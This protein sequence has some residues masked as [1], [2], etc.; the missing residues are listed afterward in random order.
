MVNAAFKPPTGVKCW[1]FRIVAILL[2]LVFV[3]GLELALRIVGFGYPSSFLVETEVQ[4]KRALV[5]NDR[6]GWR[7]FGQ[8]Y[9]RCPETFAITP[10]ASGNTVRIFVLG[11]SAAAGDPQPDFGLPIMLDA[12]LSLRYPATNFEVV[13]VA[14]TAINSHVIREIARDCRHADGDI[15]VLYMGNNEVVGPF[16]GGTVFGQQVPPMAAIRANLALK[17]T[18]TGQLLTTLL[19]RVHS[20][21]NG[22]ESWGGMKMFLDQQVPADDPRMTRVYDHFQRNLED[23]I[24]SGLQSGAGLVVCNVAVNLKDC[25]PFSSDSR[26]LQDEQAVAAWKDDVQRGSDLQKQGQWEAALAAYEEAESQDGHVAMLFFRKGQC[27]LALGRTEQ[28]LFAFRQA[29]DLDT[30]RFRCDSRL[31]E[32]VSSVMERINDPRVRFADTEAALSTASPDHIPGREFFCDHVHLTWEG[33]WLLAKTIADEVRELLPEQVKNSAEALAAW[34]SAE[35]CA[36]RLAWCDRTRLEGL[37]IMR[38]RMQ[39]PPFTLQLNHGEQVAYVQD[40]ITRIEQ[41]LDAGDASAEQALVES[42]VESEANNSYLL[43]RLAK[44]RFQTGDTPGAVAIARRVAEL[45]PHAPIAW[46]QLADFYVRSGQLDEAVESYQRGI[47]LDPA[48]VWIRHHLAQ[49]YI[50]AGKPEAALEQWSRAVQLNPAFGVAHLGMGQALEAE[51]RTVAANQHYRKALEGQF[52]ESEG[53]ARLGRICSSKG[54]YTEALKSLQYAVDLSP[55]DANI[56]YDLA[57]VLKQLGRDAESAEQLA[58]AQQCGPVEWRVRFESGLE[59]AKQGKMKAAEEEF[60]AVVRLKPDL[61]EGHL[62]LGGALLE[63]GRMDEAA[64]EF[65][66]AVRLSPTNTKLLDYLESMGFQ[67]EYTGDQ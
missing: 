45:Y 55:S 44:L 2:P 15:W 30:L 50:K 41:T 35:Q 49:A 4:G 42:A 39:E 10:Q 20:P 8:K 6:F 31:Q 1:T 21:K 17:S 37:D 13:N 22:G 26:S 23:I 63:Q 16:G 40:Q 9:A 28:A 34:P 12:M 66:Q 7:F 11:E 27:D 58:V 29:R 38:K 56:R 52:Y 32:I 59:L 36:R 60:S 46:D 53:L 64:F 65:S 51:G 14:M 54:W 33:N 67:L 24:D 25:A 48:N 43:C 61:M 47:R 19:S 57:A 62:N 5:Q 18:R 3:L